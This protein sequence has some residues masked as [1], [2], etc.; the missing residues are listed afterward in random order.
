MSD[1]SSDPHS[2]NDPSHSQDQLRAQMELLQAKLH[3]AKI[4]YYNN[5]ELE[6]KVPE[7]EQ[8]AAIAKELIRVNY[9]LQ[10]ALYGKIRVKLSVSKLLRASSR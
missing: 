7:Y 6:G 2:S 5:T 4:A 3:A 1:I 8:L 9:E 10:K